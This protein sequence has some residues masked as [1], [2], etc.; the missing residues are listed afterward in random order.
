MRPSVLMALADQ[1]GGVPFSVQFFSNFMQFPGKNGQNIRLVHTPPPNPLRN[2]GSATERY[3][4]FSEKL[5]EIK[6]ILA[7]GRRGGAPLLDLPI[8]CDNFYNLN[9]Y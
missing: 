4:K 5:Y 6:E 9:T 3:V 8:Y 2:P 1:R 7:L